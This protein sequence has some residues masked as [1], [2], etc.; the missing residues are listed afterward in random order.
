MSTTNAKFLMAY[1][2]LVGVPLGALV[3][4]LKHGKTL[5]AP[6]SVD[7]NW[8]FQ[9]GLNEL[10]LLPCGLAL[11]P[12]DAVLNITQSGK[13]LE[14]SLP[15]GFHTETSGTID[16]MTLKATLMPAIQPKA[17][18]CGNDKSVRLVASLDTGVRP[19]TLSGT[20][21]VDGCLSCSPIGFVAVPQRAAVKKGAH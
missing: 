3:G 2:L 17:A 11:N 7:G 14:L 15:N 1:V 6:K 9:S 13:N 21:A 20:V 16:G 12:E 10:G 5:T 19:R 4:V 8:Q 18:G